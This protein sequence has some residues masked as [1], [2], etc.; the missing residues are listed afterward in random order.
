M[1]CVWAS[2]VMTTRDS[3]FSTTQ[4]DLDF[5]F[6]FSGMTLEAGSQVEPLHQ[7]GGKEAT[8][9]VNHFTTTHQSN[10]HGTLSVLALAAKV[11]SDIHTL[12]HTRVHTRV[13][14]HCVS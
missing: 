9:S 7:F 3:I 2:H 1:Q 4:N 10:L 5:H 13:V 11:L 12:L 14:Q 8:N 6:S